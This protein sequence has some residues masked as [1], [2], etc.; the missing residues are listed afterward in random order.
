MKNKVKIEFSDVMWTIDENKFVFLADNASDVDSTKFTDKFKVLNQDVIVV[1][2]VK[3]RYNWNGTDDYRI[4]SISFDVVNDIID[5]DN[6]PE[7]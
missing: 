7:L 6:V 4:R 3:I 2:P 5:F 1:Q